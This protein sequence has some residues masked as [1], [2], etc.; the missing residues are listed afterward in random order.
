M[1]RDRITFAELQ[2]A[3]EHVERAL[4]QLRELRD[5]DAALNDLWRAAPRSAGLSGLF[6]KVAALLFRR[7][8]RFN[9]AL[10]QRINRNREIRE[11]IDQGLM[12][13]LQ[14]LSQYLA[15]QLSEG[16]SAIGDEMLKR[17]ESLA[18][19]QERQDARLQEIQARLGIVQHASMALRRE[20]ERVVSAASVPAAA[21]PAPLAA[22]GEVPAAGAPS[23]SVA[24]PGGAAPAHEFGAELDSYKYVGFEDQFR[25][26]P[27]E[28]RRRLADYIPFFTQARDVLDVGC[29]RGEFLELLREHAISARGIDLNHQMVE[30][31]REQGLDVVQGNALTFLPSLADGSLGGVFAAQVVEHLQPEALVG[32][33]DAAYHKLRPGA[34]IVL[35]TINPACWSAFFDSYIRDVTHV[36]PLH[37]DTL[38]Y[39]LQA[40]G[41]EDVAVRYSAPYPEE[42]RLQPVPAPAVTADTPSDLRRLAELAGTFNTNVERLNAALFTYRDYA[43][44][45]TRR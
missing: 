43:V 11:Q 13:Y 27:E 4:E 2:D 7:Q 21:A 38:K 15:V 39:L 14:G 3:R 28:I 23:P 9:S 19:R 30:V 6:G 42:N 45:G 33:L 12:Q 10:V 20:V 8:Q 26:S 1:A 41:F 35:E 31:C 22:Q 34:A 5:V 17:W 44:I 40:S 32:L 37:P 25:G 16:L 18:A 29:G 36:R 24:H